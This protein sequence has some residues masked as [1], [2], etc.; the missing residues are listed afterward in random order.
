MMSLLPATSSFAQ[1]EWTMDRCIDYAVTHAVEVRRQQVET[2]KRTNDY[3]LA[4]LDFL[5]SVEA[6]VAGQYAWGR[7]IDPETNTYNNVTT[8][9]NYY[10]VTATMPL[11]DGGYTINSF[12]QARLAKQNVQSAMDAVREDKAIDVMEKFVDALY[13]ERSIILM[14][15]KLHDSQALLAKTTKLFELGEKSRPDVVQMESQVAEDDYNLLHQKHLARQTLLALKSSMSYPVEDS[16][17]VVEGNKQYG[18]SWT[19]LERIGTRQDAK[20]FL[21]CSPG[22]RNAEYA[23]EKAHLDWKM[24]RAK[25]FPTLSF[26]VGLSTNYYKNLTQGGEVAAFGSQF[27]N[28][29]GEYAY[30]SLSIPLFSSST[31]KSVRHA[32]A[33]YQT[34]LLDVEETR[35]K[36]SDEM[37]R[38]I[39]DRDGYQQ[40]VIQMERKVQSD[41]LAY[42]LSRRKYEEGML[43]TFDLHQVS[44]TLLGSRIKLLQ[45]QMLLTIKNKLVNYYQGEKLWTSE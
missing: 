28:N 14:E 12:R 37:T 35:R 4:I 27:K 30:L 10:Q 22:V 29:M 36:V 33:S 39:L 23:A 42:H 25:L 31:M 45:M 13:A 43:S 40:E 24:Q 32:K 9:N 41:S 1:E 3:R 19:N 11:F 44:Q 38:A 18:E 26:G 5:P 15:Q 34:A 8:F 20:N 21:L 7:N 6:A 2:H 16:L 17:R